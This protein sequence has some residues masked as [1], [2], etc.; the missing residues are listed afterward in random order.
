MKKAGIFVLYLLVFMAIQNGASGAD[1]NIDFSDS[2][3]VFTWSGDETIKVYIPKND[4]QGVFGQSQGPVIRIDVDGTAFEFNGFVTPNLPTPTEATY[5]LNEKEKA[6]TINHNNGLM[7]KVYMLPE[8]ETLY[9]QMENSGV[10]TEIGMGSFRDSTVKKLYVNFGYVLNND[11]GTLKGTLSH[12]GWERLDSKSV[13][14]DLSSGIS[15]IQSEGFMPNRLEIANDK[16]SL[17]TVLKKPCLKFIFTK[18]GIQSAVDKYRREVFS[19]NPALSDPE[20]LKQVRKLAGRTWLGLSTPTQFKKWQHQIGQAISFGL[21]GDLAVLI[22]KW[23][24][25]GYDVKFPDMFPA[26]PD[27]GGNAEL[28]K[29]RNLCHENDVLFGMHEN[30]TDYSYCFGSA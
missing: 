4:Q 29:L 17:V 16:V 22:H 15:M 9:F 13:G 12:K 3:Y 1:M 7:V 2:R 6:L 5:F 14:V 11:N 8:N 24:R 19:N 18:K 21:D 27:L 10:N 20:Y 26:N 28:L 30:Y 23:Q 25:Y